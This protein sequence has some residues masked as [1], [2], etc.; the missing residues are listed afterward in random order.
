VRV[1]SMIQ[2]E[3]RRKKDLNYIQRNIGETLMLGYP[4]SLATR[5]A[6]GNS[7]ELLCKHIDGDRS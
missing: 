6:T 1:D 3:E 7:E 2:R 4:E 5:Y